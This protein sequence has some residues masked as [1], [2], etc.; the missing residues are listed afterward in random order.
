[1][2]A[3]QTDLRIQVLMREIRAGV[4][5]APTMGCICQEFMIH[6]KVSY[7]GYIV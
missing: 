5:Q 7:E 1:M 3:T 2:E 6:Y 4:L